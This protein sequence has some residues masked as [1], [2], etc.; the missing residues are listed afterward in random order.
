MTHRVELLTPSSLPLSLLSLASDP[1]PPSSSPTGPFLCRRAAA[2]SKLRL[3]QPDRAVRVRHGRARPLHQ[4]G[5][6]TVVDPPQ[7]S[8]LSGSRRQGPTGPGVGG[9]AQ[10]PCE[11]ESRG[12]LY[13]ACVYVPVRFALLR[14]VFSCRF[15]VSGSFVSSGGG[16]RGDDNRADH[17]HTIQVLS[18]TDAPTQWRHSADL[19]LA[20]PSASG[21]HCHVVTATFHALS[22]GALADETNVFASALLP[23][24]TVVLLTLFSVIPTRSNLLEREIFR[25]GETNPQTVSEV[26]PFSNSRHSGGRRPRGVCTVQ[27]G[28]ARG[29]VVSP[30]PCRAYDG[31]GTGIG[32]GRSIEASGYPHPLPHRDR[33][34]V[35]RE[36][37]KPIH[38]RD[39]GSAARCVAAGRDGG[40]DP[41]TTRARLHVPALHPPP[42][43]PVFLRHAF[44]PPPPSLA[45]LGRSSDNRVAEGVGNRTATL[46][47]II[48]GQSR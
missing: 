26:F 21:Q 24:R 4:G 40:S 38:H 20:A 2:G 12:G 10:M 11:R 46:N 34:A 30:Q 3:P 6:A 44:A 17:A 7:D 36:R 45:F 29:R 22:P 15:V 9:G 42:V 33:V 13:G 31:G 14:I 16:Q 39:G 47:Q 35:A 28:E 8:Q 5:P 1:C 25:R 41:T 32:A 19:T 43:L 37:R 48:V 23:L 18:F 27:A